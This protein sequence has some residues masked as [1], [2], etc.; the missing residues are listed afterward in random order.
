LLLIGPLSCVYV[1]YTNN[2]SSNSQ[3]EPSISGSGYLDYGYAFYDYGYV[4]Y[5]I[6]WSFESFNPTVGITVIVMDQ[7]EYQK[8]INSQSYVS[9]TISDGSYQKAS[10]AYDVPYP[11]YWYVLFINLDPDQMQVY[12]TYEVSYVSI[13][14]YLV[15][16]LIILV[17]ASIGISIGVVVTVRK[18]HRTKTWPT[19][20][21]IVPEAHKPLPHA[22]QPIIKQ[23]EIR[24]GLYCPY[25]G[26]K[27]Q[28]G[29]R[30]CENC[31]KE[32]D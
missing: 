6:K 5:S 16:L 32:L 20:H 4:G 24:R 3:I 25:C 8:L 12:I 22:V 7:D 11:D 26:Y 2:S 18:N 13:N 21:I 30:F 28:L 27:A 29:A 10:G 14:P 9:Y 15:A 31:G 19:G 17:L 23:P 1:S